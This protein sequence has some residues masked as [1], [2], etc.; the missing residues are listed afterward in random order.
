MLHRETYIE[1]AFQSL[2]D[3]TRYASQWVASFIKENY[4]MVLFL[5][6]IPV[7]FS[8]IDY[9]PRSVIWSDAEGYYQYLPALFIIK[10]VH[11]LPPGS[12]WPQF[13]EHGE[14]IDKYTCGIAIFECPF[15][16]A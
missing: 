11:Q 13:N 16:F 2:L 15:F 7:M 1:F 8:R 10:D 12:I 14:Y 4:V 3:R 5:L 9:N 6:M